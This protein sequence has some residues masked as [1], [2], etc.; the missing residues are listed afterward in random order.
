MTL[1]GLKSQTHTPL[2]PTELPHK[3]R[4]SPSAVAMCNCL[5]VCLFVIYLTMLSVTQTRSAH[6]WMAM[7]NEINWQWQSVVAV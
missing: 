7:N 5:F 4:S 2:H 3:L 1:P 6:N